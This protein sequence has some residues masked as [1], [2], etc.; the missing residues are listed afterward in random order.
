M[1]PEREDEDVVLDR[2]S[3]RECGPLLVRIDRDERTVAQLGA[4]LGNESF[5]REAAHLAD[6][7]RLGDRER[8]VDELVLRRDQLHRDVLGRERVQRERG[9]EPGDSGS[10][11]DDVPP[12]IVHQARCWHRGRRAASETS[13][14]SALHDPS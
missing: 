6:V 2:A 9:L 14:D 13:T 8:P 12:T 5:E 3:V 10:G 1:P 4:G 7:E 11:Y